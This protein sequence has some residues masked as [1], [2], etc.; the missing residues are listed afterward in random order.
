MSLANDL[1]SE[2]PASPGQFQT[3][4]WS[5][6]LTADDTAIPGAQEAFLDAQEI[7]HLD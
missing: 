3:T 2:N 7:F 1:P 4:H 5:V 6:V